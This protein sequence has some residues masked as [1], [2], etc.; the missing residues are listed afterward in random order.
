MLPVLSNRLNVTWYALTDCDSETGCMHENTHAVSFT[1]SP[2]NAAL[3][4]RKPATAGTS[5]DSCGAETALRSC[6]L[7]RG[8]DGGAAHCGTERLHLHWR[9]DIRHM[10]KAN[11]QAADI[12][13]DQ[14]NGEVLKA[15]Q[16]IEK[17]GNERL[18]AALKISTPYPL[19]LEVN[20]G[21]RKG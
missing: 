7:L 18:L 3:S 5:R 11:S 17:R 16:T 21:G 20:V 15:L 2:S 9:L 13:G 4:H 1:V 19:V 12:D 6:T 10:N 8:S 14:T